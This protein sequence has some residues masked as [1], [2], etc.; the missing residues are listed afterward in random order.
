ME[1]PDG[2]FRPGLFAHA[3]LGVNQRLGV[4]V[5]PEDAVVQRAD[6]SVIFRIDDSDRVERIQ[7]ETRWHGEGW[8]E[9]QSGVRP[10]DRVVVRGHTR[11]DDGVAVSV[12][13]ADGSPVSPVSVAK[14]ALPEELAVGSAP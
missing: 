7:V 9:I 2:R 13:H 3:D 6:G 5:V 1:N 4:T 12:R 8:I 14:E 11:L 10:D